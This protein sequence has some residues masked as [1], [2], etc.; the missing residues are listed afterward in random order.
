[1]A[2]RFGLFLC[3]ICILPSLAACKW[4]ASDSEG[5]YQIVYSPHAA[6]DTFL[7][8]TATGRVWQLTAFSDL[9]GQPAAWDLMTRIDN[10]EDL[11]KFLQKYPKVPMPDPLASP[12]E[13]RLH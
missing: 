13:D 12:K 1:M 4:S 6:R 2:R 9:E 5:R 11:T 3:I 10:N 8:D 7:L